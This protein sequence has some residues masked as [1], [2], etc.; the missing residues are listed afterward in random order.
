MSLWNSA[1]AVLAKKAGID[2]PTPEDAGLPYNARIGSLLTLN[3]SPF[4]RAQGTLVCAPTTRSRTIIA[5]STMHIGLQGNVYRYYIEKGDSAT[6]RESYLQIYVDSQK[7]RARD[8][9]LRQ[10][11]TY[12]P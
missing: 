6:E 12:V 8:H 9:V 2:T 10:T 5:I 11:F 7:N 3:V 1:R 4:M